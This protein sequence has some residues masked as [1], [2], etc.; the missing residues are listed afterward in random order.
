[1]FLQLCLGVIV[2]KTCLFHTQSRITLT[3]INKNFLCHIPALKTLTTPRP[4]LGPGRPL[5]AAADFEP[6][7]M[8][9][10]IR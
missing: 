5:F 9:F 2:L 1:M 10:S 3:A 6:S 4:R 7:N 8:R